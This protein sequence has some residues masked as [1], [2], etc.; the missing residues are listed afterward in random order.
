MADIATCPPVCEFRNY[1]PRSLFLSPSLLYSPSF[2]LFSFFFIL[3]YPSLF[4]LFVVFFP[5]TIFLESIA[6]YDSCLQ[7]SHIRSYSPSC[8]CVSTLLYHSLSILSLILP[9]PSISPLIFGS[10]INFLPI[11]CWSNQLPSSLWSPRFFSLGCLSLS[12]CFALN[13]SI[14]PITLFSLLPP[15]SKCY[16]SSVIYEDSG[17]I[18]S[19]IDMLIH[20]LKST[21]PQNALW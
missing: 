14:F 8:L 1:S 6:T 10:S 21:A 5:W 7:V 20:S 16:I 9:L 18:D 17:K 4:R 19:A 2:F 11:N 12:A 15:D 3:F 13:F